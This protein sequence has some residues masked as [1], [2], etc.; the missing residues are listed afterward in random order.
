MKLSATQLKIIE[1]HYQRIG[2]SP[3][4][5]A[6]RANLTPKTVLKLLRGEEVAPETAL[7]LLIRYKSHTSSSTGNYRGRLDNGTRGQAKMC[8]VPGACNT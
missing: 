2:W 5:L 1:G 8:G 3:T 4:K 6:Y 7:R